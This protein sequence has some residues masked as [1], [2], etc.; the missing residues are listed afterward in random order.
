ALVD[1]NRQQIEAIEADAARHGVQVTILIDFIHVLELSTV[2]A[3]ESHV[4]AG[5]TVV[6]ID[7]TLL[8]R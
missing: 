7:V 6:A 2:S 1:G 4:S 8:R 5:H 3:H